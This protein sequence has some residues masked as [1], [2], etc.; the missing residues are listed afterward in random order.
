[1]CS[2]R[3]TYIRRPVVEQDITYVALDDHKRKHQVAMLLPGMKREEAMTWRVENTRAGIR[4]MVRKVLR[5]A[6]GEVQVCYEA[7]PNGYALQR[8]IN[9]FEGVNCAV[10]APSKTPRRAGD[11]VKTDRRDARKLVCLFRAGEL[12][13]VVPP[14]EEEEAARD[15]CRCREAAQKRLKASR[16]QLDKYLTRNGYIYR[17]G[18]NWTSRHREWLRSLAFDDWRREKTFQTY[19]FG[20]EQDEDRVKRLDVEIV[21]AA[22]EEPYRTL[23]GFVRCFRGFDT[24]SAMVVTSELFAIGRFTT[25]PSLMG[26]LGM[27]PGEETTCWE[28]RRGAITKAGNEHVRRILVESAKHYRHPARISKA[29]AER[30]EGQPEWVI[31]IADQAQTRLHQKYC[32]LVWGRNK[33]PNIAAIAVARELVGFLWAVLIQAATNIDFNE[34]AA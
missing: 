1:M 17:N 16:H 23:V 4:K 27:V 10:V 30:R 9:E 28:P 21:R 32:R 7:G 25:A 3:A 22:E 11:R 31:A 15:L 33:H 14:M 6:P 13:V 8:Q 26:F 18:K 24:L 5:M 2:V 20:V 29:L 12:V 19:L 34:L